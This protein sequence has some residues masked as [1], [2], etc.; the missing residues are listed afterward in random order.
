MTTDLSKGEIKDI[1]EAKLQT[2]PSA[3]I[4]QVKWYKYIDPLR[5]AAQSEIVSY[6]VK[7]NSIQRQRAWR[8]NGFSKS[9]TQDL[10]KHTDEIVTAVAAL[11]GFARRGFL[12][13]R[14]CKERADHTH[15]SSCEQA[16]AAQPVN[17]LI[18]T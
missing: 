3:F 11:N 15:I 4:K 10:L 14:F 5:F 18:W 12:H 9:T 6:K 2:I 8:F 13:C 7:P 17:H 16:K 1:I